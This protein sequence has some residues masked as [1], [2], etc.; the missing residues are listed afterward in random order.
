VPFFRLA[1]DG[2]KNGIAAV[3]PAKFVGEAALI[4]RAAGLIAPDADPRLDDVVAMLEQ[5]LNGARHMA[6]ADNAL[7]PIDMLYPYAA[8]H[9]RIQPIP[10]YETWL[11]TFVRR[12]PAIPDRP[13]YRVCEDDY[14]IYMAGRGDPPTLGGDNWAGSHRKVYDFNT[15]QCY[16]LTH[17]YIYATDLGEH[18]ISVSWVA[19]ALL[20]IVGKACLWKNFDLFHEAAF[21][22]L[23]ADRNPGTVHLIDSLSEDFQSEAQEM[24]AR[25]TIDEVYHELFV[26]SLFKLRR[27][28]IAIPKSRGDGR[29]GQFL[30]EFVA[31]LGSKSPDRIVCAHDALRAKFQDPF[32]HEACLDK[33]SW[34]KETANLGV[35]FENEIMRSGA[36]PAPGFYAEYG[37]RVDAAIAA[38]AQSQTCI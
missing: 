27:D 1:A 33:L 29:A 31:S 15:E 20:I 4:A 38:I 32:L 30:K 23:S 2:L 36:E 11:D 9:G 37:R 8:L 14:V 22:L 3:A 26:Y 25:Q 7:R 6:L 17:R 34:L 35:L 18:G 5:E 16:C 12:R 24:E 13:D 21:C 10:Y 19:A 28:R